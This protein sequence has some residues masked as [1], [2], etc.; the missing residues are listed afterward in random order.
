MRNARKSGK[1]SSGP[2]HRRV[3][4]AP[5]SV[6]RKRFLPRAT[7]TVAGWRGSTAISPRVQYR[8]SGFS[9]PE[10]MSTHVTPPSPLRKRA[11]PAPV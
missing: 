7:Y 4:V 8:P 3:H 10:L 6:L 1:L 5:R 11:V 9:S 2:V